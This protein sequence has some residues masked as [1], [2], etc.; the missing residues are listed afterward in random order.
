MVICIFG[1][2]FASFSGIFGGG[3]AVGGGAEATATAAA[4]QRWVAEDV[5]LGMGADEVVR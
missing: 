5:V 2:D 1:S 3:G 4:S